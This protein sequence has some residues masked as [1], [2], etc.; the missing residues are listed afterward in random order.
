M[1]ILKQ[2]IKYIIVYIVLMIILFSALLIVSVI[3]KSAIEENC[4]ES[5]DQL[6]KQGEKIYYKSFDR[7]MYTDNSTDSIMINIVY[8]MD[9]NNK[10]ES[11]MK[12]RRNYNPGETTRVWEDMLGNLPYHSSRFSMVNEF[13]QTTK[14]IDINSYEYARYWHGYIVLLR[15]LL[16][17]FDYKEIIVIMYLVLSVL[18]TILL[19]NIYRKKGLPQTIAVLA[20]FIAVEYLEWYQNMQGNY[21]LLIALISSVLISTGKITRKHLNLLLFIES[22]FIA[23]LDL[24]TFPLVGCVVPVIIYNLFDEEEDTNNK[25]RFRQLVGNGIACILGF[26]LVWLGKLILSDW[27]VNTEIVDLSIKQLGFRLG[28]YLSSEQLKARMF[29]RAYQ[30]I[31]YY[32]LTKADLIIIIL[33]TIYG[34]YCLKKYGPKYYFSSKKLVYYLCMIVP[35]I[36][37]TIVVEHSYLHFFFTYRNLLISYLCLLLIYADNPGVKS[38]DNNIEE[39]KNND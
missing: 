16:V 26:G 8:S 21:V 7:Q 3:P 5:A 11:I 10:I 1:N 36:W 18:L 29:H 9:D 12:C 34:L 38:I 35:F 37:Y 33:G 15:P 27:L 22:G 39:D 13:Y 24:L 31:F 4:K 30:K 32:G 23:Y 14:G 28:M 2:I 20:A 19:M 6:L 25:K 17:F